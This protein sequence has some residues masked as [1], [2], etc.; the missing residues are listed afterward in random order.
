[1]ATQKAFLTLWRGF[2]IQ[3]EQKGSVFLGVEIQ[4]MT[5]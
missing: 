2:N 4:S 3:S 5:F 1:M